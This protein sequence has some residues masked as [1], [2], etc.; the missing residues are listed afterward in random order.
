MHRFWPLIAAI[1]L[2]V[3]CRDGQAATGQRPSGSVVD[4]ILSPAEAT[5]RFVRGLP[6]VSSLEGGAA[7]AQELVSQLAEAVSRS[8]TT[9]VERMIVSRAEYGH[10]YYPSSVFTRRP[11][12]LAPDI[13]WLLSSEA[14]AK[15]TRR[16]LGR[17]GGQRVSFTRLECVEELREGDNTIRR[18]CTVD[19]S[20]AT[21]R[22]VRTKL[23]H[24]VIERGG[25]AKILSL[26]GDY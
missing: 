19:V 13:A 3:A 14:N 12:E 23:F 6:V 17:L 8:D 21:N 16:L 11:Y 9:A 20:N 22:R 26:S 1:V 4:S 10:L 2:T 5:A 15:G 24:S 7:T 18:D 25:Q